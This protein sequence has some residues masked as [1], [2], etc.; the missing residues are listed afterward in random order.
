MTQVIVIAEDFDVL[1]SL[2]TFGKQYKISFFWMKN[3]SV[4]SKEVTN[5]FELDIYS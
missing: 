5:F 1:S 4:H 2:P 3:Q